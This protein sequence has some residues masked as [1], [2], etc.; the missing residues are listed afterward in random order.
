M[1]LPGT[2][3][4]WKGGSALAYA[5]SIASTWVWAPAMFIAYG[6]AH[7][8]GLA[9]FLMFLVPN[10]LTLALF[11]FFA[12]RVRREREG[13]SLTDAV[14]GASR[15]QKRLHALVSLLVLVCSTCVQFLGLYA[16]LHGFWGLGKPLSCLIVSLAALAMVGRSG[17]KGS[18]ITDAVKYAVMVAGGLF[19]LAQAGVPQFTLHGVSGRATAE[20]W[21]AF[22][23]TTCIG[24][25]SAPYVDNTFWQRVFSVPKGAVR[26]T[27]LLSAAMFGVVPLLFGLIGFAAPAGYAGGLEGLYPSGAGM[28]ALLLC[29]FCAL[30]STLD[31]NL[32]AVS[33]IVCKDF[34]A[35]ERWARPAMAGLLAASSA[36]LC[37]GGFDITCLFLF[38]GTLR[39][40]V[41]VPTV[42]VILDRFDSRRLYW[43]TL[44][45]VLIAPAGFV[46]AGSGKWLFTVLALL[47][48][49]IGWQPERQSAAP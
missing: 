9:G 49:L 33:A 31:S 12:E 47:L 7:D 2:F 22:G 11:A 48:P 17:I 26:R 1:R 28:A 5:A 39:T 3:F 45:A 24:L 13:F 16:V 18:I 37:V 38:Y 44:A 36:L 29:A 32:C 42:L 14:A 30:L 6:K 23:L 19:L 15:R 46:A 8:D 10:V 21:R 34:G 25:L 35:G 4:A 40:C 43:A 41:A 20:V 27:F